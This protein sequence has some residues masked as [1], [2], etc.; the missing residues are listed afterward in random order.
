[1]MLTRHKLRSEKRRSVSVA[2]LN[3][4]LSIPLSGFRKYSRRKLPLKAK[5]NAAH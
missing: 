3:V 2:R 1:M 5:T 4:N